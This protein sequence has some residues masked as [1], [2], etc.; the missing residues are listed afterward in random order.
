MGEYPRSNNMK[1]IEM[2]RRNRGMIMP[3][4]VLIMAVM[5][6]LGMGMLRASYS[7]RVIAH[8]YTARAAATSA[9][10]SGFDNAMD[11]AYLLRT[12]RDMDS[13]ARVGGSSVPDVCDISAYSPET[14]LCG[15]GGMF[16]GGTAA[17][18]VLSMAMA[19]ESDYTYVSDT[20]PL[21]NTS[22]PASYFYT[23][24]TDAS[25]RQFDIASYGTCGNE[26]K[27]VHATL[28][29]RGPWFGI[30]TKQGFILH[31]DTNLGTVPANSDLA[32]VTNSTVKGSVVLKNGVVVP[33]DIVV[34]PGANP[35]DV[36]V[37][38]HGAGATGTITSNYELID[39]PDVVPPTL[40]NRSWPHKVGGEYVIA[41][42]GVYPGIKTKNSD[43]IR[44]VGNV[45]MVIDGDLSLGNS[46]EI[47][48]SAGS[49]LKL[50]FDGSFE[51]KYGSFITNE[52]YAAG[53]DPDSII[54]AAKSLKMYGTPNCAIVDLKNSSDIIGS[55]YAPDALLLLHNSADF[56]GALLGGLMVDIRNSGTFYYVDG[57]YDDDDDSV[58]G[59]KMKP[60][61]WWER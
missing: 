37:L 11:T 38:N 3:L 52:N 43:V 15:F 6:I 8:I 51:A 23:V 10:D 4:V 41:S 56:Y 30:G 49:S 36:V 32:L 42:S 48:V 39:F 53:G 46:S 16:S 35:D 22:M 34:G 14:S 45:K 31:V 29:L 5:L 2:V 33:G 20:I 60:G 1:I 25:F 19:D 47:V 40:P 21:H 58:S 54:Q 9:A 57:L 59:L 44:V 50:Y 61:S 17:A 13:V 28:V 7:S 12:T 55:V 26:T 18:G 27:E 24:E